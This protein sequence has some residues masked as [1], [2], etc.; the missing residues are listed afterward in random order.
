MASLST[1]RSWTALGFEPIY[2]RLHRHIDE[3]IAWA[4]STPL[5]GPG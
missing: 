4:A 5:A 2:H 1:H 3:R